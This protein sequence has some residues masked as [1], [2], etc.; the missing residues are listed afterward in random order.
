MQIT[1]SGSATVENVEN[2]ES[3][4]TCKNP[5]SKQDQVLGSDLLMADPGHSNGGA[6][7]GSTVI[8]PKDLDVD[9]IKSESLNKFQG[10]S[11]A[12]DTTNG[13][14][15]IE[16]DIGDSDKTMAENCTEIGIL[17]QADTTSVENLSIVTVVEKDLEIVQDTNQYANNLD[18]INGYGKYYLCLHPISISII[19][20]DNFLIQ[21]HIFSVFSR[22]AK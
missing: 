13:A 15:N 7:N 20:L 11:Q 21:T 16:I 1:E 22:S 4:T 2:S 10:E 18:D 17:E 9:A 3:S 12:E 14:K 19:L 6:S 8:V 5:D